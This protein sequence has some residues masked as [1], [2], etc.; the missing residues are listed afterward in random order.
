MEE[1]LPIR[2]VHALL[3]LCEE[4][5]GEDIDIGSPVAHYLSKSRCRCR[6]QSHPG[7]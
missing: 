5:D 6:P 1:T 2:E 4:L 7:A 3:G